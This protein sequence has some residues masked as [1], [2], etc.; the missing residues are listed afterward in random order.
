MVA[1][2]STNTAL[3]GAVMFYMGW[4]YTDAWL[5]YF[6]VRALDVDIG[7]TEY[8]V[9][10]L[11]IFSPAVIA[12][13]AGVM[14]VLSVGLSRVGAGA[15]PKA[16]R[17]IGLATTAAGVL[18]YLVSGSVSVP[19]YPVLALLGG[20]PLMF[21]LA[22]RGSP[23]GR[24]LYSLALIVVALCGLWMASLY[25]STRGTEAGRQT[26]RE[27]PQRTA[28]VVYSAR[29]L[30]VAGPGVQ[31]EELPK[32]TV[33]GYRY[34]GLRVLITRGDRYYL[35]PV[36]WTAKVSATYVLHQGDGLRVELYAGTR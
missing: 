18:G 21:A 4:A 14:L 12:F 11:H 26:A 19:T 23:D 35:L 33:F 30:A 3:V 16:L 31:V 6:N 17:R 10:G 28:A 2:L 32:G 5:G 15:D 27:L 8:V 1:F 9:R 24:Y 25:A 20:G 22:V 34:S 29:R 36:G 7:F 13:G